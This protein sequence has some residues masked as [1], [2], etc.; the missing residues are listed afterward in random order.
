MP[1]HAALIPMQFMEPGSLAILALFVFV[2]L[3]VFSVPLALIWTYHKRKIEEMRLQKQGNMNETLRSEF[4]AVREEIKAL[5]DTTT[6][7]DLSIDHSLHQMEQRLSHLE[8]QQ[9]SLPAQ[10]DVQNLYLGGRQ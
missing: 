3:M 4:E 5:R 1:S 10:T 2:P 6:Q 9:R 7:Y 8:V